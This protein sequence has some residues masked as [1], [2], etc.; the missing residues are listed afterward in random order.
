M[1]VI[2]IRFETLHCVLV[3]GGGGDGGV[4]FLSRMELQLRQKCPQVTL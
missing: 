3:V 2:S 4:L 1:E